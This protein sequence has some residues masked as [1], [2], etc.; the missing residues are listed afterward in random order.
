MELPEDVNSQGFNV[1]LTVHHFVKNLLWQQKTVTFFNLRA[2]FN[3]LSHTPELHVQHTKPLQ[4]RLESV[5][6]L[7]VSVC[8]CACKCNFSILACIVLAVVLIYKIL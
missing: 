7:C 6:C 1:S 4:P 8:V 5:V 2:V 3:S